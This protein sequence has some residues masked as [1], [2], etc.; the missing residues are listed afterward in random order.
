MKLLVIA[1][2]SFRVNSTRVA[3]GLIGD[4]A[5]R[6][7]ELSRTPRPEEKDGTFRFLLGDTAFPYPKTIL[8]KIE[9]CA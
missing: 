7:T 3:I 6:E 1:S 5:P 4:T 9:K 2:N 8:P